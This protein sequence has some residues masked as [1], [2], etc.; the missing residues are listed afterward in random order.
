MSSTTYDNNGQIDTV[1]SNIDTATGWA[2]TA[3][4]Y[5]YDTL[6]RKT[7][8]S[9]GTTQLASWTWDD[10]TVTGGKGQITATT[11]RDADGNTLPSVDLGPA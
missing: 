1:K 11:S 3:L 8:V 7:S 2:K 9:S 4:T 10:P 6:G 5:A